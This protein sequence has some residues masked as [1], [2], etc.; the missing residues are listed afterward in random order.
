MTTADQDRPTTETIA[1]MGPEDDRTATTTADDRPEVRQDAL[2]GDERTDGGYGD[3]STDARYGDQSTDAGYGAQQPF[4]DGQAHA[5]PATPPV[6]EAAP[7]AE[8][9]D[10]SDVQLMPE[11]HAARLRDQW[12]QVQSTFVDDPRGAVSQADTLVAEVMQTLASGFAE[13]KRG[14]EESWQRGEEAGT[15]DL[16]Q[17]LQSYRAFFDRLLHT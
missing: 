13:H 5:A 6:V 9:T 15:E 1:G 4:D 17:A 14:L 11:R 2:V 8:R 10:S 7:S 3:Q 16:R 12:R